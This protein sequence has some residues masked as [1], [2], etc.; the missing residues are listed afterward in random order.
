MRKVG[1]RGPTE[2]REDALQQAWEETF[3]ISRRRGPC[4][5]LEGGARPK[6]GRMPCN[7]HGK[8]PSQKDKQ[9]EGPDLREA[10]IGKM[11]S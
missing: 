11:P 8:R 4:V 5:R 6:V 7:K 3:A 2:G 1:R 10:Q 9:K